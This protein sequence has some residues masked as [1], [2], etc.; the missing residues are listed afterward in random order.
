MN[1]LA[2]LVSLTAGTMLAIG[3]PPCRRGNPK[4]E[5]PGAFFNGMNLD[6]ASLA[7]R[8]GDGG[9]GDCG[10]GGGGGGGDSGS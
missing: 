2:R 6:G 9:E 7:V 1:L 10:G 3:A 8:G 5:P 4:Q